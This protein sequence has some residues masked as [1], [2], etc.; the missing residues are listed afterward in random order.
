MC[1]QYLCTDFPDH[2][3]T[4]DQV[5]GPYYPND[6][7]PIYGARWGGTNMQMGR[8]QI[9]DHL[10]EDH[11]LPSLSQDSRGAFGRSGPPA[12]LCTT[13]ADSANTLLPSGGLC[14]QAQQSQVQD[15]YPHAIS[16]S[17]GQ[18]QSAAQSLVDAHATTQETSLERERRA[19]VK[20]ERDKA[21]K[22]IERSNNERD[23]LRICEL[24]D[25]A[26]APKNTLVSRSE[27]SCIR[28]C[29]SY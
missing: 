14:Q 9:A 3:L 8:G 29:L 26:Y 4:Q 28:P 25:I 24:L 20:K 21:R 18:V 27:C 11:N 13:I 23:Y 17:R 12:P 10:W 5:P 19:Q 16:P 2:P 7:D 22:Q 1:P 6:S 15:D